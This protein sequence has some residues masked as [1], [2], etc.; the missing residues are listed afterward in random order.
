MSKNEAFGQIFHGTLL[1]TFRMFANNF[2]WRD[3]NLACKTFRFWFC[4]TST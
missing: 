4:R 3:N 1:L 2:L